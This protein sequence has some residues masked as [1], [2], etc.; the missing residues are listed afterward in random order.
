MV[1]TFNGPIGMCQVAIHC[2]NSPTSI[3][4]WAVLWGQLFQGQ[5]RVFVVVFGF[6][7]TNMNIKRR[8]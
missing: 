7:I 4:L 1:V 3:C 6:K 2:G 5:C 8:I